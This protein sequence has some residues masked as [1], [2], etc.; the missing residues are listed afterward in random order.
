[1]F[2][3]SITQTILAIENWDLI[4]ICYLELAICDL[5]LSIIINFCAYKHTLFGTHRRRRRF[6]T[7]AKVRAVTHD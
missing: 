6:S 3:Y 2:K 4:I 1:M 5:I 7:P